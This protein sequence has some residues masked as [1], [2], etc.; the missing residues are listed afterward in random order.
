M[1]TVLIGNQLGACNRHLVVN[2]LK[3]ERSESR[4]MQ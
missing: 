1:S 2:M 4:I 3:Q